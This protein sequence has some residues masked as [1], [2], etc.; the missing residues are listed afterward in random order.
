MEI[1]AGDNIIKITPNHSLYIKD[2]GFASLQAIKLN[3]G[4][5]KWHDLENSVKL[6]IYD[7]ETQKFVFRKIEKIIKHEGSFSTYTL[8][9]E[10]GNESFIVN[11]FVT[12]FE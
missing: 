8:K 10:G 12:R 3:R 5:K 9:P 1:K 2:I 4:Y 7:V 6:L 11:G